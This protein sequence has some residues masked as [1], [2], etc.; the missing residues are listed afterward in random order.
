MKSGTG[1]IGESTYVEKIVV[2]GRLLCDIFI[3]AKV[4]SQFYF[5]F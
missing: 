3:S 5:Y 1:G 2:S 4:N